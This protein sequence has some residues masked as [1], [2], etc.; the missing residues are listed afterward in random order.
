MDGSLYPYISFFLN[1]TYI[2]TQLQAQHAL[3]ARIFG[4]RLSYHQK[5]C[6]VHAFV[7]MSTVF[8][9]NVADSTPYLNIRAI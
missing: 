2:I 7:S 4:I 8:H 3:I 5:H 6:L 9:L 1:I